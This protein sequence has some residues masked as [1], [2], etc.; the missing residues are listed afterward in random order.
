[1]SDSQSPRLP[2]SQNPRL[3]TDN[4]TIV[5]CFIL[6][7]SQERRE[8]EPG[9]GGVE[10]SGGRWRVLLCSRVRAVEGDSSAVVRG[11]SA[12]SISQSQCGVTVTSNASN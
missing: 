12:T 9:P 10:G 3:H 5:V 7:T 6:V 8:E 11:D 4:R 1:M 2:E